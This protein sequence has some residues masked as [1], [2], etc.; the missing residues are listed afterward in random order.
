[1]ELKTKVAKD[2]DL[3]RSKPTLAIAPFELIPANALSPDN[4]VNVRE[5]LST[6]LIDTE[7]FEVVERGQLQKALDELKLGKKDIFDSST[8][9]K[10]GKQ[11]GAR[12]VLIGSISDRGE[13]AVVNVRLI[14]TATG[15]ARIAASVKLP[16]TDTPAK[17]D[18]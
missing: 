14:D 2:A 8:A 18:K 9:Q 16:Q 7:A 11:V 5:D 1:M 3:S 12:A 4:A 15:K 10:L 6:A 13:Y 17:A